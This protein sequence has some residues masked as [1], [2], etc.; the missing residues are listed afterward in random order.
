MQAKKI[1]VYKMKGPVAGGLAFTS[2][3][4]EET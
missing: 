4:R 1:Q 2:D 3:V